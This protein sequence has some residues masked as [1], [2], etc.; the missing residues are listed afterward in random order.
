VS[1]P[2]PGSAALEHGHPETAVAPEPEPAGVAPEPE[3]AGVERRL[4]EKAPEAPA[5]EPTG[6]ERG[7][8]LEVACEIARATVKAAV[9]HERRCGWVGAWPE[10]TARGFEV[11]YKALGPDLWG[12]TAGI[13][14][15][16]AE[17]ARACDEREVRACAE[18]ALR[19][20]ASRAETAAQLTPLGLYGGRGGVA[21]ALAYGARLL[22]EPELE[23]DARRIARRPGRDPGRDSGRD[24]GSDRGG[25]LAAGAEELDLVAGHA[26]T[27][28]ALLALAAVL[29]E[30]EYVERAV[31]HGDAL[32]ASA[33]PDRGGRSWRSPHLAPGEPALAG[34]SHGAA[35]VGAALWEL[36]AASGESRFRDT[37]LEAFGYER[38]LYDERVR[39]WPDLREGVAGA[40]SEGPTYSTYWCHGAPGIAL[41]R[42]RALELEAR[43]RGGSA[44]GGVSEGSAPE[45]ASGVS[46]P[47]VVSEGPTPR[48][49]SEGPAGRASGEPTEVADT[50][51]AEAAVALETTAA[52]VRA[53]LDAGSVGWSLCHGLA[54][55]AE[56]VEEG[57]GLCPPARSVAHRV[58]AQGIDRYRTA[59]SGWPGGVQGGATPSLFLGEAGVGRFYLRLAQPTLPSLMIVRPEAFANG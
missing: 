55:N 33:Q 32:L 16:L 7:L 26:G 1:E 42:I 12:G 23:A 30:P 44:P 53:A 56:I 31:E 40:N 25:D 9:W 18:G 2:E 17:L 24:P 13:G 51:R 34:L 29:E 50:L 59:E 37:A 4:P 5:P 19:H 52:W 8:C 35:G 57:R 10:E 22:D 39:N 48:G 14:V 45:V 6:L 47:G 41:S 43:A 20:A 36:A 46:P 28:V 54:G 58:A 27:V 11:T 21:L 38:A 49:V 3:P 15:F